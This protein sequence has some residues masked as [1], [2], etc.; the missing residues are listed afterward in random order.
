MDLCGRGKGGYP[1]IWS[2]IAASRAKNARNLL[3]IT[4][5]DSNPAVSSP[6]TLPAAIRRKMKLWCAIFRKT[7]AASSLTSRSWSALCEGFLS[8]NNH[9]QQPAGG[10]SDSF[11][12]RKARH[13]AGLSFAT[14]RAEPLFSNLPHT[15]F[16]S[17]FS[18]LPEN[19]AMP[20]SEL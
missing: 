9:L 8:I 1:I 19:T 18:L 4:R 5:C 16:Q 2:R 12:A 17:P 7:F 15:D 20:I 14:P 11:R 6:R 13:S 10:R 3:T